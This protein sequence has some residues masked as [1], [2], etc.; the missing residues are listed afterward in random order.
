MII[1]LI[2]P[3]SVMYPYIRNHPNKYKHVINISIFYNG[4]MKSILSLYLL[5]QSFPNLLC[6]ANHLRP[7]FPLFSLRHSG[8]PSSYYGPVSKCH[9]TPPSLG[10]EFEHLLVETLFQSSLSMERNSNTYIYTRFDTS[11][12]YFNLFTVNNYTIITSCLHLYFRILS[13][14]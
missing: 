12:I 11:K 5:H 7:K 8:N 14:S 4:R 3:E 10:Y 9:Q 6:V 1:S 2:R 13:N